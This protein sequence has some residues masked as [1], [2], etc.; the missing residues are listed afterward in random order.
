M[1]MLDYPGPDDE[2]IQGQWAALEEFKASKLTRHLAV[3]NFNRQ[4]L[5]VVLGLQGSIPEVNQIPYGVGYSFLYQKDFGDAAEYVAEN[6]KRGVI[7]QA[8]SPLRKAL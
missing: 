1:I 5:D 4:Q 6:S 2:S 8:W 3:S 7:V